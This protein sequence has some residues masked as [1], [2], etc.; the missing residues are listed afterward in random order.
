MK[1]EDY[2]QFI[3]LGKWFILAALIG[4][5]TALLV[6]GFRKSLDAL[7]DLTPRIFPFAPYLTPLL[8]ALLVGTLILRSFPGA[9][10]EGTPSYLLAINRDRGKISLADTILKI[11][12][13]LISLGFH[14]SGG[15]V[16][17]LARIGSGVGSHLAKG[18]F[19]LLGIS[20]RDILRTATICGFSGTI[21]AIFHSPI[22]GGI[23]A[24]EILFRDTMRYS[25]L[26]PSILTGATA[27]VTSAF[28]LGESPVFSITAPAAPPA[29]H[30]YF[31]L[32]VIAA[33]AGAIGM[34]FITTFE[35]S[36][37]LFRRL[38][39][40][41]PSSTIAAGM[42]LSLIWLAGARWGLNI[43]SGLF[44]LLSA[45]DMTGIAGLG[46]TPAHI[47]LALLSVLFI[48]ILATVITVRSGMSGGFTGPMLIV[49]LASGALAAS[50]V[51]VEPGSPAYFLFLSCSL[52]AVLGATLN[53]PLAAIILTINLFGSSYTL[54]A[55]TGSILAFILFKNRTIYEYSISRWAVPEKDEY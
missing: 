42:I 9:G 46:F 54:S 11:P 43:S 55:S 48:K 14:G 12:A 49:G 5:A 19:R 28:L 32:P 4:P 33:A 22:G 10:G 1:R 40:G 34:I 31:W 24:T 15:I 26:F 50:L 36:N 53:V 7:V 30:V 20:E 35:R 21:S 27:Y 41:Q 18:V 2:R 29:G 47:S 17:P 51:G 23:F 44:H 25:E 6:W 52:S 13:S 45:G 37:F 16:G 38:K 3:T 39:R 8:G